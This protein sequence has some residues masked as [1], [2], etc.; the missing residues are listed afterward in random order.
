MSRC[1]CH[2]VQP[3]WLKLLTDRERMPRRFL[4]LAG[5]GAGRRAACKLDTFF[6]WWQLLPFCPGVI[7]LS[8]PR[9]AAIVRWESSQ[10]AIRRGWGR[11]GAAAAARTMHPSWAR[12]GKLLGTGCGTEEQSPPPPKP[13]VYRASTCFLQLMVIVFPNHSA[14]LVIWFVSAFPACIYGLWGRLQGL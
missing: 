12:R 2:C 4:P 3:F 14:P 1:V 9:H 10:A 5:S 6:L 13:A 8:H 7:C 11:V